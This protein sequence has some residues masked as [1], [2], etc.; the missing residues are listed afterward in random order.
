MKIGT[1]RNIS[2]SGFVTAMDLL[3]RLFKDGA[4]KSEKDPIGL[5]H[6][7]TRE[8]MRLRTVTMAADVELEGCGDHSCVVAKP[9]G[10]GTNGG[11]RC[12]ERRLRHAVQ[13]LRAQ[14]QMRRLSPIEDSETEVKR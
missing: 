1:L 3:A 13:V 4:D 8:I 7:A 14:V 9:K 10:M 11:C 6:E 2:A 12:D 5:I